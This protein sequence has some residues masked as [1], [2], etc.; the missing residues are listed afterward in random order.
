MEDARLCSD[1]VLLGRFLSQ[2]LWKLAGTP[3]VAAGA[4]EKV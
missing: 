2:F 1:G 3:R 4:R